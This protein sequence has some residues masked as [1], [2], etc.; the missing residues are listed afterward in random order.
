MGK[1]RFDHRFERD[2]VSAAARDPSFRR[3]A[4]RALADHSFTDER[5][6]WLWDLIL[7]LPGRELLNGALVVTAARKE[8]PDDADSKREY[9]EMAR[10]VLELA[11]D[12]PR[13]ALRE[14]ED[15]RDFH[16]LNG[17]MEQALKSLK[18][19][20][21]ADAKDALRQ[22]LR[23]R[24]GVDYEYT[25]WLE[26]WEERQVHRA[27]LKEHPEERLQIPMRFMP[28][29]DRAMGG[30]IESGEL[31]LIVGTTGRGK[32]M[33]AAN[34]AFFAS[35]LGFNVLYVSTEMEH[36]LT[37]TRLDA[38]ATG[39]TYGELKYHD[40]TDEDLDAVDLK[41]RR[42]R[43][44]KR[45]RLRVVSIPVRRC[46]V[47]LVE[48]TADDMED[49][50]TPVHLL[51]MDTADHLKPSERTVSRRD[52]ETAAYWDMKSIVTERKIAGWS[53]T[54]APKDVVNKIATA[55]NVGE[56]YDKARISD[57]VI[58]LNQTKGQ[59]RQGKMKAYLAKNRQ[60]KS[61]MMVELEVDKARM[62]FQ[63]VDPDEK[64]DD[65]DE[66]DDD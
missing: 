45:G 51:V 46:T 64:R 57:I 1:R 65:G 19:G 55:E 66:E 6:G 27:Y 22:A 50:G 43:K 25:D 29:M 42:F 39:R 16:L 49:D 35:G 4:A 41:F 10:E 20:K 34:V 14:L 44:V 5:Y 37:A 63:E 12:A 24:S 28:S 33:F 58:T 31:G 38:R 2:I 47:D 30:G 54:H 61:R 32:S 7:D 18:K 17:G 26:D 48:Q 36:V 60:G 15:Y 62:H 13:A 40:M 59:E 3:A 53:T 11:P 23:T 21:V 56:S 9:L 8:F 52:K